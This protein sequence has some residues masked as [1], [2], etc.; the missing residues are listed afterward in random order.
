MDGLILDICP[1]GG[2][3]TEEI[4]LNKL[5]KSRDDKWIGGV[6][7]GLGKY[8]PL[9]SWLWRFIFCL[10]FFCLGTGLLV[11]LLLWIFMPQESS[12]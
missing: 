8:T 3:V 1:E 10:T 2:N 4:W 11:Y 7:G 9:P 6:C 5:V 12:K